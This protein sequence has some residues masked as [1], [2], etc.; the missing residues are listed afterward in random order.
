MWKKLKKAGSWIWKNKGAVYDAAKKLFEAWKK[1][2]TKKD[3]RTV[4]DSKA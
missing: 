3:D 2:R 1:K 4:P